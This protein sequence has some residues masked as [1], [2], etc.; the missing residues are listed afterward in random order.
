[1]G[2]P[3]IHRPA[4]NANVVDK[5]CVGAMRTKAQGKPYRAAPYAQT[6]LAGSRHRSHSS[7]TAMNPSGDNAGVSRNEEIVS[8]TMVGG[9]SVEELG[10]RFKLTFGKTL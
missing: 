3:S 1:M 5:S 2:P 9:W 10:K 4:K 6:A 8:A 7:S